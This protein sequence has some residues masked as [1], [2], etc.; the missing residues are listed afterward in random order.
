MLNDSER[1]LAIASMLI[2]SQSDRPNGEFEADPEYFMRVAYLNITPDFNPLIKCGF[3]EYASECKQTLAKATT[4]TETETYKQ[5]QIDKDDTPPKG[6]AKATRIPENWEL[7][8][9]LREW[10]I[11]E[12]PRID[13]KRVL[14]SFTDYWRS[15]PG[16]KG[17]KLDWDATWRNWVRRDNGNSRTDRTRE[18]SVQ[19]SERIEREEFAKLGITI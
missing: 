13:I 4:E 11:K 6:V 3:L 5:R 17:R 16:A 9:E 19:R 18:S 8:P 7:S 12:N 1:V 2:A 10:T 14:D 15:V